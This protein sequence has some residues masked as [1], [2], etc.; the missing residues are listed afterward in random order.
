MRDLL[1]FKSRTLYDE[2]TLS[3]NPVD[4]LRFDNNF[5]E[6][7]LLTDSFSAVKDQDTAT[8]FIAVYNGISWKLGILFQVLVFI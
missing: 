1:G 5:I 7:V 4:I 6:T 3:P 2:Y 8:D